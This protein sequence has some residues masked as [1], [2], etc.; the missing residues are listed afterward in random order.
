MTFLLETCKDISK[1][2]LFYLLTMTKL[3]LTFDWKH[4]KPLIHQI[5]GS[6]CNSRYLHI[7][8]NHHLCVLDDSSFYTYIPYVILSV[9]CKYHLNVPYVWSTSYQRIAT[10]LDYSLLWFIFVHYVKTESTGNSKIRPGMK[11]CR[12]NLV[13]GKISSG[14]KLGRTE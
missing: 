9:T 11:N 7:L 1:Y 6:L 2:I 3:F 10:S 12:W 14:V 8:H 13:T 5:N 4:R